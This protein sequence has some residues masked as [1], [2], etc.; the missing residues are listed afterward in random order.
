MSY[1]DNFASH[2]SI[3]AAALLLGG[4]TR[5]LEGYIADYEVA[6][7]NFLL[8][9]PPASDG[10]GRYSSNVFP[11]ANYTCLLSPELDVRLRARSPSYNK[12]E[13]R[14]QAFTRGIIPNL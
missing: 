14:Q 10:S 11:A 9:P 3:S 8:R 4:R 5:P 12:I 7:E 13:A 6:R 1:S 2:S